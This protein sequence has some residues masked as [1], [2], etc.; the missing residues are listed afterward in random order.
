M[1]KCAGASVC[2]CVGKVG[3]GGGGDAC[4]Y[5]LRTVFMDKILCF[6]N[7]LIIIMAYTCARDTTAWPAMK[8]W[9]QPSG[10]L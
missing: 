9:T 10:K 6:T 8:Y 2:V 7:P 4:V 1:L 5:E 3:G